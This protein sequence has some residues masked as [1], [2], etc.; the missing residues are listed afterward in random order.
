[1]STAAFDQLRQH[2]R[3]THVLASISSCLYWDQNTAMPPTGAAWRGEQL[4]WVA[5]QLH[6]RQTSTRHGELLAAAEASLCQLPPDDQAA[7]R[8]N[9]ALMRQQ[10]QRQRRLDPALVNALAEAQARGYSLWQDARRNQDFPT[11]APALEA[12]IRLRLEQVRQLAEPRSPWETLAQPFEPDISHQRLEQLFVPLR[13]RL[14]EL[15]ERVRSMSRPAAPPW[16]M[17]HAVQRSLCKQLLESWGF[18]KRRCVLAS[19]PHP[20]STDLGPE[21]FRITSRTLAHQPLSAFLA[22]AHEWGHS[23]YDQGLPGQE[24]SWFGLPLAAPTSMGVHESQSLFWENR[25]ARGRAF[26]QVWAPRFAEAVGA[27]P[28]GSS[29]GLWVAMNPL[30]PGLIRVEAG[31]LSYCLH[32]LLRYD[33]E[34]D[35]LERHM[36]VADLP[37]RWCAHMGRY[38]DV[39]PAHVGEGCLQDVHWSE[40]LF[41]YFPSYALGHLISAQLAEAMEAGIGPIEGHV[42]AG[43]ESRLLDWLRRHVH[44]LGR[45]VNAEQLVQQVTGRPLCATPFL[46]Y[47]E[48]KLDQLLA[49]QTNGDVL[50]IR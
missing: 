45:R 3:E 34:T 30:D 37:E 40:G 7:W 42:A 18:D 2:Q 44:P 39:T 21:D 26:S 48:S 46:R 17:G 49:V 23:L 38:L 14:P 5:R 4:A 32:V 36:P 24:S 41:G 50:C 20:F 1:M 9:L 11:F 13:Q 29:D 25:V 10:R 16:T 43:E 28:W 12:L 6:N 22:T 35:L 19:S 15:V 27:A 47:L 33:L 8:R 31:E